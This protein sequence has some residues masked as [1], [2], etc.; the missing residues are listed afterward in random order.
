MQHSHHSQDKTV[1]SNCRLQ[2]KVGMFSYERCFKKI[3]LP[4]VVFGGKKLFRDGIAYGIVIYLL[5]M[6]NVQAQESRASLL[7]NLFH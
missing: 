5:L 2:I 4:V 6:S 7:K 1:P 3:N